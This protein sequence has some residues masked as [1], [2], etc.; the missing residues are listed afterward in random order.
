MFINLTPNVMQ[1]VNRLLVVFIRN[2]FICFR[3]HLN[4]NL[5]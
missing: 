1:K 5:T 4:M 2:I 3:I